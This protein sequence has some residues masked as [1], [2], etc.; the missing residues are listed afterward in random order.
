MLEKI[1]ETAN[2]LKKE[3][4]FNSSVGIILGTGLG[5][6]VGEID[7]KYSISYEEIPNFPI[8]TVEGHDGKLIFGLI[9]GKEIIV[10]QGRF[11]YYE[12]YD[13]N[14]VVFPVRVMK[15]L[16]IKK[17]IISN[18]SGGVNPIYEIGDLMIINDH[19]N[20]IPN[21]LIGENIEELGTRFPDM[22]DPYCSKMLS[23][24]EEIASNNNIKLQK[25][26]YVG[27][28]GPTL[29]TP[30][31]YGYFRVIGGDTVGMSTVPEVIAARHMQMS[32]FAI[33]VITD[34]GVPGKIKKITHEDVQSVAE[35]IEPKLTK[36]IK[37]LV[38]KI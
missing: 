24:A 37:E 1:K 17:L 3:T 28:T 21:P 5:G 6:L 11:H 15:F 8:S 9:E 18:A 31:E 29:E 23:I 38:C 33:S 27:V 32:C 10:M 12:G 25:G 14:Q 16:G 36:I 30:A 19:I 7:I 22:S 2:F 35:K 13:I 26:T 20:L 4:G 34:L